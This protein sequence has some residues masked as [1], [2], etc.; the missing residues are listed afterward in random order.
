MITGTNGKR[1]PL[2]SMGS[3]DPPEADSRLPIYLYIILNK[4]LK[5]LVDLVGRQFLKDGREEKIQI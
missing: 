2:A 3:V 1:A 4:I 5:D